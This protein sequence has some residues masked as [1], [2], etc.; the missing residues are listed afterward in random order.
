M[1]RESSLQVAMRDFVLL[2]VAMRDFVLTHLQHP[3]G[4]RYFADGPRE[5]A[6]CDYCGKTQIGPS[7]RLL[8]QD[9][10][11]NVEEVETQNG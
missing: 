1:K 2:Q 9:P 6:V 4:P 7:L 8:R 11:N 10:A 3:G 5:S